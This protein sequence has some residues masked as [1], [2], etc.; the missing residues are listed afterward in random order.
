MLGAPSKMPGAPSNSPFTMGWF[1]FLWRADL[2]PNKP[3]LNGAG[4]KNQ[5]FTSYT[6]QNAPC[7]QHWWWIYY[8]TLTK[9]LHPP[10]L[11]LLSSY[12][13]PF[14]SFTPSSLFSHP[15]SAFILSLSLVSPLLRHHH[16]TAPLSLDR[17]SQGKLHFLIFVLFSSPDSN[18]G[19][20]VPEMLCVRYRIR[21]PV[22]I[23]CF[24]LNQ[25]WFPLGA[26]KALHE[27]PENLS[28]SYRKTLP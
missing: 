12:T 7:T 3:I 9:N 1:H 16:H 2:W 25:K 19:R 18:S 14:V 24:G 23:F 6:Q 8:I 10:L 28:M 17:L 4:H 5:T 26:G 11:L 21:F 27:E 22:L 15:F 20:K 13:Q